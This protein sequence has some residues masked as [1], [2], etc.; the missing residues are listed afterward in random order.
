M[1]N[2]Q[3]SDVEQAATKVDLDGVTE[4]AQQPNG[5]LT[6][7]QL[8]RYFH[9][10][11]IPAFLVYLVN[12][13]AIGISYILFMFVC[14]IL[15]FVGAISE[16]QLN[17]TDVQFD[18]ARQL[19]RYSLESYL[20]VTLFLDLFILVVYARIR[21]LYRLVSNERARTCICTVMTALSWASA[22]YV[23]YLTI[24]K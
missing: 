15:F 24:T 8:L 16:V 17:K 14:Y 20:V 7:G 3:L 5:S 2:I 22:F 9:E 1:S 6:Y 19:I 23:C 13:I 10:I 12:A 11:H 21:I 18:L 4:V